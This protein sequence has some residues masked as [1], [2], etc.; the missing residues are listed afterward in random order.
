MAMKRRATSTASADQ[1]VSAT[2]DELLLSVLEQGGDPTKTGRYLV[3]FKEGASKEAVKSLQARRGLR[4]ARAGDFA[5]QAVDLA[6]AG[7][8]DA[9]VFDE[10]GVALVGSQASEEHRLNMAALADDD[11]PMQSIDPEYFMFATQMSPADYLKGVM[12]TAEMIYNDL[13][14]ITAPAGEVSAAVAGVT[15]GLA[16]CKVPPSSFSG[17]GIKVAVLDTGFDLGHP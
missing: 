7:D 10:I 2:A 8:A 16:A 11:S 6:Q 15:W 13:G 1:K 4:V 3:T 5:A 17:S 14:E 9:V 12:R